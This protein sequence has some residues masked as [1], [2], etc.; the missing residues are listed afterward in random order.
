MS[1]FDIPAG[2]TLPVGRTDLQTPEENYRNYNSLDVTLNRR[3]ANRWS[4]V[5]SFLYTW[6]DDSLYG[7]PENPNQDRYNR[8]DTTLWAVKLFG[9]YRA[10]WDV[11]VSPVLRHQAGD[12]LRRILEVTLRTG[13][14]NY[15]AESFGQYRE[16][17]V[18]LF[19]MRFEKEVRLRARQRLGLFFDAFNLTNTNAA[20]TQDNVTGRRTTTVSGQSVEYQRFLRPT[21]ILA[22]R[23]YRFGLKLDF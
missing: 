21:V 10:P 22:P 13:T 23:V 6:I 7:R 17:N 9:T 18:T 2:V 19:D 12:R 15:T 20:Q 8:Y 5:S 16:D 14:F 11:R 4:L 1:V 3:M